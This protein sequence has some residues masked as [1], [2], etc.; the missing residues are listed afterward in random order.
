MFLAALLL[1]AHPIDLAPT[2]GV[3]DWSC[4]T[5]LLTKPTATGIPPARQA[6]V[7]V[8]YKDAPDFTRVIWQV[9][10]PPGT[11][12]KEKKRNVVEGARNC[13]IWTADFLERQT[14][15]KK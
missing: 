11:P 8:H 6:V 9:V 3:I 4:E 5:H 1:F 12:V 10:E 2:R 13:G 15:E 14:K 7:T